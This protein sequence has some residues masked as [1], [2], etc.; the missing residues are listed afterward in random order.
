MKKTFLTLPVIVLAFSMSSCF[1]D[2]DIPDY[3][4]WYQ[5]NMKYVEDAQNET[6]DGKHVYQKYV[7]AWSPSTFVLMRWHNDTSLTRKNLSPLDNSTV[8]VK[9]R[10]RDIN[11]NVVDSSYSMTTYGDSLFRTKVNNV[12]TGWQVAL[13]NMHVGDSVTLVV[14]YS[15]GYGAMG[16]G[17]ILPYSTLIFDMMLKEVQAYETPF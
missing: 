9:Y 11:R 7:P 3:Q 4:E 10:L 2:D 5:Q 14:P 17:S 1:N 15:A 13:T 16:Q 12:I 8:L 6:V